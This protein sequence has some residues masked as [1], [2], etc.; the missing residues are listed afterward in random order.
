[1]FSQDVR[2]KNERKGRVKDSGGC[3]PDGLEVRECV[4]LVLE[5][6]VFVTVCVV[7]VEARKAAPLAVREVGLGLMRVLRL[8]LAARVSCPLCG[9]LGLALVVVY[10]DY[11]IYVPLGGHSAYEYVGKNAETLF[12][13]L[14]LRLS[15]QDCNPGSR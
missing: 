7:M 10:I 6:E 11:G 3:L 1:M 2:D 13:D 12:W 15:K 14:T 8:L 5:F 4:C 9:L